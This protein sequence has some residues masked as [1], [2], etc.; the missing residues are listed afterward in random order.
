MVVD[1]STLG[2]ST[3]Y[4]LDSN[5]LGLT[6][7]KVDTTYGMLVNNLPAIAI[8]ETYLTTSTDRNEPSG[9]LV[10]VSRKELH[11]A[12]LRMNNRDETSPYKQKL[13]RAELESLYAM[14]MENPLL[15]YDAVGI[16][17]DEYRATKDAELAVQ[18]EVKEAKRKAEQDKPKRTTPKKNRKPRKV[19]VAKYAVG[20][21]LAAFFEN[22]DLYKHLSEREVAAAEARWA[23][24]NSKD[25]KKLR[26]GWKKDG[27]TFH[28]AIYGTHVSDVNTRMYRCIFET[29]SKEPLDLDEKRTKTLME[30]YLDLQESEHEN[31][32]LSSSD[33]SSDDP[34]FN[35]VALHV[36]TRLRIKEYAL[37]PQYE[38]QHMF[39]DGA[40]AAIRPVSDQGRLKSHQYQ[41]IF[42]GNHTLDTWYTSDDTQNMAKA[43]LDHKAA[44]KFTRTSKKHVIV[45]KEA[46]A[47]V[48]RVSARPVPYANATD[49][50]DGTRTEDNAHGAQM[51]GT[52]K[53]DEALLETQPYTCRVYTLD[54]VSG[55]IVPGNIQNVT[56]VKDKTTNV[57]VATYAYFFQTQ[58]RSYKN[59]LTKEQIIAY[60]R[61]K[62]QYTRQEAKECEDANAACEDEDLA[63]EDEE[64]AC[65]DEDTACEDE[66]AEIVKKDVASKLFSPPPPKAA[67]P[68]MVANVLEV[69]DCL[70]GLPPLK[71]VSVEVG[72]DAN[73]ACGDEDSACEDKGA[74]CEDEDAACEDENAEIVKK[75]AASKL[76]SPPPPKAAPPL[77]VA[78][79]LEVTDLLPGLPPLKHVSE[80]V[81]NDVKINDAENTI[82]AHNT[83][84]T[85]TGNTECDLSRQRKR[86]RKAAD[87]AA[88]RAWQSAST[89]ML[90][91]TNKAIRKAYR[92]AKKE[93]KVRKQT[94]DDMWDKLTGLDD[95]LQNDAKY[96]LQMRIN[97]YRSLP[98]GE[99][100]VE[101][102][103]LEKMLQRLLNGEPTDSD[104][105]DDVMLAKIAA[106]KGK[107][108]A[109]SSHDTLH[110]D[111][112]SKETLVP[113]AHARPKKKRRRNKKQHVAPFRTADL[114][115]RPTVDNNLDALDH[116]CVESERSTKRQK[117][118]ANI[119]NTLLTGNESKATTVDNFPQRATK[120]KKRKMNTH[121]LP[122]T[123]QNSTGLTPPDDEKA[124]NNN[125]SSI[126]AEEQG[127]PPTPTAKAQKAFT[128]ELMKQVSKF[129]A[130]QKE[131]KEL[132]KN[133]LKKLPPRINVRLNNWKTAMRRNVKPSQIK[134]ALL[135][136]TIRRTQLHEV[137]KRAIQHH[138]PISLV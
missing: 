136:F 88:M 123:T 126:I 28:G 125:L 73:A 2:Y 25:K 106:G 24:E 91:L 62:E 133:K 49:A 68:L 104:A 130:Q 13:P 57:K 83:P 111:A 40:V 85:E 67:P 105:S 99:Y 42:P 131:E 54:V 61:Y 35:L 138:T 113:M 103:D 95:I 74:A 80:E 38:S 101:Y 52:N 55:R 129:M 5:L 98:L 116:G 9:K 34:S 69:T 135:P 7:M 14:H 51:T 33:E 44:T 58:P 39:Y 124:K 66:N 18:L 56:Y 59:N 11:V 43:S 26:R 121:L 119:V 70:P 8:C 109:H 137:R 1:V 20:T 120:K 81:L 86:A 96:E 65:E 47:M 134:K 32:G 114:T 10:T 48:G 75:D 132:T 93:C 112:D 97:R 72:D 87:N 90:I 76:F 46:C 127:I 63:C 6:G 107:R 100:V 31:D 29:P 53:D 71:H 50:T 60:M 79:E 77:M 110:V 117:L 23:K 115:P 84:S 108:T 30:H 36:G 41:C 128:E 19:P 4:P 22:A 15:L 64:A 82:Q 102:Y 3:H 45:L 78:N 94:I 37:G 92:E 27:K 118:A 16:Y 17:E 21:K 122:S 12:W 89:E